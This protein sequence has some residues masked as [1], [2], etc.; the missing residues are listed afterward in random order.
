MGSHNT[1]TKHSLHL[2]LYTELLFL[3]KHELSSRVRTCQVIAQQY[4]VETEQLVILARWYLCR[5]YARGRKLW[6][7]GLWTLDWTVDWT[8][9][10]L[11]KVTVYRV[12]RG[13][14][15]C[16]RSI[17][18]IADWGI[19]FLLSML[20]QWLEFGFAQNKCSP[21]RA[22]QAKHTNYCSIESLVKYMLSQQMRVASMRN[23]WY[24]KQ[25]LKACFSVHN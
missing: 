14:R 20:Q 4:T 3:H 23:T 10:V 22:N 19:Y 9:E 12:L 21:L 5:E 18:V 13:Q 15:S 25:M 24:N 1:H 8:P 17:I 16:A 11:I 6:V 7:S 2:I